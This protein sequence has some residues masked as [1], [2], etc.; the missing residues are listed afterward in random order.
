MIS[1]QPEDTQVDLFEI[2]NNNDDKKFAFF[3]DYFETVGVKR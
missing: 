2:F 1:I 3:G